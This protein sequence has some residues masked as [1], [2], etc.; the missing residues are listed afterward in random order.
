MR[1]FLFLLL[2]V[3]LPILA[4]GAG[5]AKKTDLAAAEKTLLELTNKERAKE[6][7]KPL[8]WNAMLGTVARGHAQNMAKQKKEVHDLDGKTPYDRIRA[9]GYSYHRAG[10]NVGSM[11][12]EYTLEDLIKAW[13]GSKGHRANILQA[14]FEEVGMGAAVN[15][16][17]R[18]YLAQV[19]ARPKK[20]R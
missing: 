16:E 13:M 12:P 11:T 14:E 20:A 5:E 2:I 8:R 4:G 7:L 1:A 9:A 18:I 19:F 10:E 3:G 15:D 6:G 17:G